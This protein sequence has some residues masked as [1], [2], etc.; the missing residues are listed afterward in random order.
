[1]MSTQEHIVIPDKITERIERTHKYINEQDVV[2]N[3]AS[4]KLA[5]HLLDGILAMLKPGMRE[6]EAKAM[7][8][9]HFNQHGIKKTW[10]PPY[11]R[12]GS[13]TLLT[14]MDTAHDDR[15]LQESDIVFI[16]I[17]IVFDGVEGDAGRTIVFGNDTTFKSLQNV[18]EAMFHDAR[19]FWRQRNPTGIA[20]YEYIRALAEK[21]GLIFC[22]DPAGHLIG[23]FPHR[24]WKNGINNYP[25]T[26]DAGT[27]ILEIQ[28]RH[29]ELP[30]GSFYENLLY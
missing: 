1:M 4:A 15:V 29:R 10:H 24:G 25:K 7:A 23:E 12:F 3:I 5:H 30:Y 19:A 26:I 8:L 16:D 27:W 28:V 9:A 11:V 18:S 2:K 17:G 13:N 20:L 22:L 14:F 21:A 6:S